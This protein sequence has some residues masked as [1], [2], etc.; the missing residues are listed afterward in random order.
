MQDL[1]YSI[2]FLPEERK[3]RIERFACAFFAVDGE[4]IDA[5]VHV[6]VR[7]DVRDELLQDLDRRMKRSEE[8]KI[9]PCSFASGDRFGLH[10]RQQREIVSIERL[11]V[12][13]VTRLQCSV[14]SC[15]I[16]VCD[17]GVHIRS[18]R[19]ESTASKISFGCIL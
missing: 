2:V 3:P 4:A 6:A 18:I 17:L 7:A 1:P 15:K 9:L 13:G 5:A 10:R 16:F 14:P 8:R 19:K 12:G 11:H